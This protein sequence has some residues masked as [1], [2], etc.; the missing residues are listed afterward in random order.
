MM[1]CA[2][3][4]VQ[5]DC[6]MQQRFCEDAQTRPLGPEAR[7]HSTQGDEPFELSRL[8]FAATAISVACTND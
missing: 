7:L 8:S 3:H 1:F 2:H 6:F 4:S 5:I